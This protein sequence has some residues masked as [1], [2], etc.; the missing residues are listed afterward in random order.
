M[1]GGF[2]GRGGRT[3]LK[4]LCLMNFVFKFRSVGK[5]HMVMVRPVMVDLQ[6]CKCNP[7]KV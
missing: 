3:I 7:H 2:R 1:N 4:Y 5:F 6:E